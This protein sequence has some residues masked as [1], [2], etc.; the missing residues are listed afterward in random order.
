[1]NEEQ[2]VMTKAQ[3]EDQLVLAKLRGEDDDYDAEFVK[4]L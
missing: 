2:Y 4:Y 3:F 1:M